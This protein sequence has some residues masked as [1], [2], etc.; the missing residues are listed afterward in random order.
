MKKILIAATCASVAYG[1][2]PVFGAIVALPEP[3]LQVDAL[4]FQCVPEG[5]YDDPF[6]AGKGARAPQF[7]IDAPCDEIYSYDEF[8]NWIVGTRPEFWQ[9]QQYKRGVND[10]C[11]ADLPVFTDQ[12]LYDF[13]DGGG[14]GVISSC[15][16]FC[17]G[18]SR[19]P[20]I[21]D[22]DS[23]N[24][25]EVIMPPA[26][27]PLPASFWMLLVAFLLPVGIRR[28]AIM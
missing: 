23:P 8:S 9:W 7:C 18:N 2:S 5:G 14:G 13:L 27:V 3:T 12:Q 6:P 17:G 20:V 11:G 21:L 25:H 22:N 24:N 15:Q 16:N 26:P 1:C 4:G 19:I 28:Y 10:Q